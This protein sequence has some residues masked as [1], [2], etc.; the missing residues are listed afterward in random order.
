MML[1]LAGI[2]QTLASLLAVAIVLGFIAYGFMHGMFRS[3]L[4]GMQALVSFVV[5]LTFTPMITEVLI[6]VDMP[7]SYA[8]PIAVLI[9]VIGTTVGVHMLVEKYISSESIPLLSMI[10]KIG[11]A[12]V[13][14]AAGYIASGGILITLSL[15]PLPESYEINHSELQL[16]LGTP[17]LRTFAR[18]IE[19][20]SEKR[21]LL[22]NGEV[23]P[24]VSSENG[25]P[26]YPEKPLPPE[27]KDLP[28][29]QT[30]PPFVPP[31][32][33]IWSEPFVD[34]NNNKQRD[35]NEL[36]YLDVNKDRQF[37]ENALIAPPEDNDLNRFVGLLERY[38]ENNWWR[39]RVNQSTWEDLYPVESTEVD[40]VNL[41]AA[42]TDSAE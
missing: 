20:D 39:W 33:N 24:T 18:I 32:P 5:T 35:D 22:L 8:F 36:V 34:L 7:P 19:P 30:P 9:L 15:M 4:A 26:Q 38:K 23:W 25:T 27:P 6:A 29:G 17:L 31:P 10:D 11:G 40:P 37:T 14:G 41:D 12:F 21:N 1:P 28:A 42:P 2:F 16:D 13:G 3:V